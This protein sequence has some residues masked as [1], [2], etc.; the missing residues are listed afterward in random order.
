MD[1]HLG[2]AREERFEQPVEV[3]R[4]F[5]AIAEPSGLFTGSAV[6]REYEGRSR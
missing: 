2:H 1:V 5:K 3:A 6:A 4:I